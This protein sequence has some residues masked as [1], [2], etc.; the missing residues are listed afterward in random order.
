MFFR[1]STDKLIYPLL[2]V[3]A[4][5]FVSYRPRYHLRKEMPVAFYSEQST[6]EKQSTE[7][8][9][10]WGYW[11]SAQMDVQFQYPHGH[12]L[13]IEPPPQFHVDAQVFGANAAA[14]EARK[15]YWQRLQQIWD[16][17][18]AWERGYEWD[19]SWA[20]DPIDSGAQWLRD[21]AHKMVSF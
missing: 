18:E 1:H 20:R 2:A 6:G 11:E 21:E 3:A 19:W 16:T 15:R 5:F 13:P 17:P 14:P 8:R 7:K 12:P 4:L 10:A 9:V